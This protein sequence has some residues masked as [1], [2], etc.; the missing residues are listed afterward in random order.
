MILFNKRIT[1]G[2]DQTADAQAG[3]HLCC[4]QTTTDR[5]SQVEAQLTG[6]SLSENNNSSIFKVWGGGGG[7]GEQDP[8]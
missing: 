2:A 7:G 1:K 4:L 6:L 5:F 3:L 8:F